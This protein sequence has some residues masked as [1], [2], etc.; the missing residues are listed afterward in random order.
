MGYE[1]FQNMRIKKN[2][3]PTVGTKTLVIAVYRGWNPTHWKWGLCHKL[4]N[5]DPGSWTNQY[6]GSCHVRVWITAH[7]KNIWSPI[8]SKNTHLLLIII[9]HSQSLTCHPWNSNFGKDIFFVFQKPFHFSQGKIA[10]KYFCG[11]IVVILC[12]THLMIMEFQW[13]L[14]TPVTHLFSAIYWDYNNS[15][16]DFPFFSNPLDHCILRLQGPK[17]PGRRRR[18]RETARKTSGAEPPSGEKHGEV[19]PPLIFVGLSGVLGIFFGE[20]WYVLGKMMWYVVT[21]VIPYQVV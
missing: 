19:F 2:L 18:H 9:V 16:R 5:K 7:S 14:V 3:L 17:L 13:E 10:E 4:W 8:S 20:I 15:I 11:N 12:V 1:T 21:V 6:H